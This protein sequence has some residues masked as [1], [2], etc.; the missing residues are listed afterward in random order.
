MARIESKHKEASKLA[1]EE[2]VR[3]DNP[4]HKQRYINNKEQFLGQ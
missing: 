1:A 3:A 2:Q 4:R